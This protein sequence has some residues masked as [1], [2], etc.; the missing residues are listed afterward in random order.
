[1]RAALLEAGAQ[2]PELL[3]LADLWAAAEDDSPEPWIARGKACLRLD[4]REEA[5]KAFS[6]AT[7]VEPASGEA[8]FNLGV[9]YFR[10]GE[11]TELLRAHATLSKLNPDLA[12]DLAVIAGIS[13][14]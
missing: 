7:M 4:R 9:A 2:W 6:R 10:L 3:D 5:A 8:W 13:R 14:Q 1:M 11:T 12:E